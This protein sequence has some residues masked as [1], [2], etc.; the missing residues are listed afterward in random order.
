MFIYG[1][2]SNR[3]VSNVSKPGIQRAVNAVGKDSGARPYEWWDPR[4]SSGERLRERLR[5]KIDRM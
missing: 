4:M 5:Y 1:C 3:E 2:G